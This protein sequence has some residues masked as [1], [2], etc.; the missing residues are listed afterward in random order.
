MHTEKDPFGVLFCVLWSNLE[1]KMENGK[2]TQWF[3]MFLRF[4][5]M[6][7]VYRI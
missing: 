5:I 3:I 6:M 2:L 4:Y 1:L 7:K